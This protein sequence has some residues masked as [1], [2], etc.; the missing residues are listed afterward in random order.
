MH[1][2]AKMFVG[3]QLLTR[4]SLVVVVAFIANSGC[5]RAGSISCPSRRSAEVSWSLVAD[6][7]ARARRGGG[8]AAL[9]TRCSTEADP[10]GTFWSSPP[11]G[12]QWD[13][14]AVQHPAKHRHQQRAESVMTRRVLRSQC[15][16]NALATVEELTTLL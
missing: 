5:A 1:S 12:P 14:D 2:W 4:T 8:S 15:G 11:S 9:R 6:K 13:L 7:E 10:R 16:Q 3:N